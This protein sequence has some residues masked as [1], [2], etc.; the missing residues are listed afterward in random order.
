VREQNYPATR[1][2]ALSAISSRC[3]PRSVSS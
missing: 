2:A 3:L 1:L